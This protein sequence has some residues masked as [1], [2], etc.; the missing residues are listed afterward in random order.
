MGVGGSPGSPLGVGHLEN[1]LVD[2]RGVGLAFFFEQRDGTSEVVGRLFVCQHR[3]GVAAGP[4]RVVG[5]ADG[6]DGAGSL[7]EVVRQFRRVHVEVVFVEPLEN[8]AHPLVQPHASG[9]ADE[10]VEG[11]SH[12][13]V[14]ERVVTGAPDG[15]DQ[16]LGG[17]GLVERLD[18]R[19]FV[20]LRQL[21]ERVQLEVA[22]HGRRQA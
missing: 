17:D 2:A 3:K 13:G 16:H 4:G 18:E 5:R 9:G 14:R 21:G 12:Q 22:A 11:A 8:L 7:A 15:F 20:E 19:V 6:V 10:V 1:E